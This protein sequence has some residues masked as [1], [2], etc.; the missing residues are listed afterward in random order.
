MT[1]SDWLR[2]ISFKKKVTIQ[3]LPTVIVQKTFPLTNHLRL[4]YKVFTKLSADFFSRKMHEAVSF[5]SSDTKPVFQIRSFFYHFRAATPVTPN[6]G[7]LVHNKAP[8]LFMDEFTT[9]HRFVEGWTHY[10]P[11]VFLKYGPTAA[12]LFVEGRTHQRPPVC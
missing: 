4:L 6:P 2:Q 3:S 11:P 10:C 7:G 5:V 12:H 8:V 1:A 9:A